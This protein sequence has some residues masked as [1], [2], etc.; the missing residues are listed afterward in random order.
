MGCLWP[1]FLSLLR[2][3]WMASCPVGVSC[4]SWLGVVCTFVEAVLNLTV[5]VI[6]IDIKEQQSE[7]DGHHSLLISNWMWRHWAQLSVSIQ[8]I[9]YSLNSS[10]LSSLEIG[11]SRGAML[12]ALQNSRQMVCWS[13][14]LLLPN[15]RMPPYW[16]QFTFSK[17]IRQ[18]W[19]TLPFMCF[20]K[21]S[22]DICS[23]VFPGTEMLFLGCSSWDLPF[24][25]GVVSLPLHGNKT[26]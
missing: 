1:Q 22:R 23:M 6:D 21:S 4:T 15:H 17:A 18:L 13:S 9:V 20:S 12:K 26:W 19:I 16:S 14:W 3:F 25:M 10:C 7:P 5:C 8:S 11:M 2:S 24:K